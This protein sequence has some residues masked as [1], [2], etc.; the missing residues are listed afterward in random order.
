VRRP[1]AGD[2]V[3]EFSQ[4][5]MDEKELK[6]ALILRPPFVLVVWVNRLA[7]PCLCSAGN[8]T[9]GHSAI[10]QWSTWMCW[11]SFEPGAGAALSAIDTDREVS[12][13]RTRACRG[14][15]FLATGLLVAGVTST[16]GQTGSGGTAIRSGTA[17]WPVTATTI[18]PS[19]ASIAAIRF[20][21][22]LPGAWECLRRDARTMPCRRRWEF[23]RF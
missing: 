19:A 22:G 16:S 21:A 4:R 17:A 15:P 3:T 20:I 11:T 10:G 14:R 23:G 18:T 2:A 5:H 8:P 7:G 9:R 13:D 12:P 1:P 6:M